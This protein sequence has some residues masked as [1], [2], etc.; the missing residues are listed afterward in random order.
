MEEESREEMCSGQEAEEPTMQTEIT[1]ETEA[2]AEMEAIQT[3][4][5]ITEAIQT[6]DEK[7]EEN[8]KENVESEA[9]KATDVETQV[10]ESEIA[11][12]QIKSEHEQLREQMLQLQ[13]MFEKRIQHTEWEEAVID[14]LHSEL[15]TYK[16]DLYASILRP[17][18]ADLCEVRDSICR[19]AN[20]YRQRGEEQL[21]LQVFADYSL[22]LEDILSKNQ[23]NVIRSET[24]SELQPLKQRAIKKQE[25]Q[26]KELH[27]KVAESLTDGYVYETG[28]V[29]VP[30]KVSI[31]FYKEKTTGEA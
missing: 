31:Y 6:G 12:E 28:R 18:L 25:T 22:D 21:P 10:M 5:E 2:E 24:G 13:Q 7:T 15:K 14:R 23:I 29:L 9:S 11:Q 16:D 20:A 1:V 27:G 8:Q 3:E 26:E 4:D 19:V 17:V 30:E